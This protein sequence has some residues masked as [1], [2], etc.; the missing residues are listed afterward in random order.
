M[1]LLAL[2]WDLR[3]SISNGFDSSKIYDK[4][5]DF[6]IDIVIFSFMDVDVPRSTSYG[7]NIS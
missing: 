1:H 2:F 3:L 6:D 7:V 5:D 4:R